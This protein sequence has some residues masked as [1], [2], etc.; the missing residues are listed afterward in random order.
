LFSLTDAAFTA[1]VPN[2]V[3]FGGY[4]QPLGG[5]IDLMVDPAGCN[6]IA[7]WSGRVKIGLASQG[8]GL[9]SDAMALE[10]SSPVS[11]GATYR[12][13]F[14]GW[15]YA[16]RF[17]P[18]TG[19]VEI[20]LSSDPHAFGTLVFRGTPVTGGWQEFTGI[21]VAPAS[22]TFLT[23]HQSNSGDIWNNVDGFSLTLEAPV[24]T[25]RVSWGRIKSHFR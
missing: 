6:F 5:E 10:L 18:D 2:V 14:H 17:A 19:A 7:P 22:A 24:L 20:G 1:R 25:G 15:A 13:T 11:A 12:M 4:P 16:A 21:I 23:V 9:F 8:P 3:A